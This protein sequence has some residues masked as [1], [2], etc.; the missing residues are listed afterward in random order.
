[1]SVYRLQLFFGEAGFQVI[2]I[3]PVAEKV[4]LLNRGESYVGDVSSLSWHAWYQKVY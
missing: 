3:D 1:M 4:E 2:G